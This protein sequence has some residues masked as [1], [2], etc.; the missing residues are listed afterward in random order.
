M[1]LKW[2]QNIKLI[3][4]CLQTFQKIRIIIN[5]ITNLSLPSSSKYLLLYRPIILLFIFPEKAISNMHNP[6]QDQFDH[7]K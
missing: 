2:Q 4:D 5:I 1:F 3:G 7:L 6:L